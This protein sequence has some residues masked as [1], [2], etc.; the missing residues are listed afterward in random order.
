[1]GKILKPWFVV[2]CSLFVV[3]AWFGACTPGDKPTEQ[4]LI[5]HKTDVD[6]W[7]NKRIE[8]LKSNNG[9]LNLAGLFWLN[10]G[11]NSFGSD[12]GNDIVFPSGKIAGK[13]GY[14]MVK[15]GMVTLIPSKD[16]GITIYGQPVQK[17]V[18]VFHPDSARAVKQLQGSITRHGSLEWHVIRRDDKMG[19]RLRDLESDVL[20]SFRGIERYPVEY[21]WRVKAEFEPASAG[22]TIDITNVLGQTTAQ[23]LAGIYVFEL[24]GKQHR[25]SATAGTSKKLFVVFADPTNGKETYPAGKFI[26]IDKPDSTGVAFIDFNKSYNPPCAFTEFATC[27]L[28]PKEN[29]LAAAITAGEKNYDLHNQ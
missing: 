6:A 16:A 24:N 18:V 17:D 11:I 25:L 28:P 29:I 14:F 8:D 26:Y 21:S 15:G 13:A 2:R 4:Q 12:E 20:K 10:E 27:P 22:A 9:W 7:Y 23:D 19:I 3:G 1:M 5:D